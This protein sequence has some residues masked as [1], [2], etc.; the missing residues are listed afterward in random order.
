MM[1]IYRPSKLKRTPE[2]IMIYWDKEST[3]LRIS[4]G[5]SNHENDIQ[6]QHNEIWSSPD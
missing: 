6:Y 4:K 2:C 5:K 1:R 3:L